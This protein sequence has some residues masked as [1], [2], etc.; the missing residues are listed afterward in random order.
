LFREKEIFL[1]RLM[2]LTDAIVIAGSFIAAFFITLLVRRTAGFGPLA[3][4]EQGLDQFLKAYFWLILITPLAWVRL[5]TMDGVYA[6]FRT[7][8]FL[9][10]CWRVLRMGAAA[11]LVMGSVVFALKIQMASRMYAATFAVVALLGLY[12]EKAA[13][14][15]FLDY[16]SRQGY[17]L[18]NLLIVG[19]GKRAQDF[20]RQ[21]QAHS[22]WGLKIVGLV[23]DDPRVLGKTV[24]EYPVI[25]RIRD[26][27]RILRDHVID[28]VIFVIPRMWLNRIEDVILHCERE[29]I[30][31]AVSVDLFKPKLGRL[32]LSS[33]AEIPLLLFETSRAKEW[34][35]FL[36]RVNDII[37]AFLVIV[38]LTPLLLVMA[39][40]IKIDSRGPVFFKQVRCGWNGRKFTLFKF[41]SMM[42]GAEM[43]K[44]ELFRHNEMKGPVF[45]IRRDPRV[46]RIGRFM[47]KFSIDEFPQLF[48][49][50]RGDMSLVGPRPPLPAEVELY[51]TWHRRRLS[52][53]PGITCIW[54]V[55]G[56]NKIDF[57]QWMEMDLRYID[58]FSLWL[59]FKILV[60][61]V[62]VVLTGYGAV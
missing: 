28:R 48:N 53:K 3:H 50:L 15:W 58:N 47:R 16:S 19:T 2:K 57:D 49:V 42:Q 7:K 36:K 60:R 29:G 35:L 59:D 34:Q 41:R 6:N 33:F 39:A 11:L 51:E 13:W 26:I 27:P 44:K 43:R 62:F 45:K 46:T 12:F 54:Q 8:L 38:L 25:G 24:L 1:I 55:S 61:T 21:V 9:E 20:I 37:V 22:N 17:N 10:V 31:T 52:M 14:R 23:D 32:Y 56:R 5:M 4:A 18:V 30:S 40:L